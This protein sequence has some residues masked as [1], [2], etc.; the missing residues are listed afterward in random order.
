MK[1][2]IAHK[3]AELDAAEE[4]LGRRKGNFPDD[5]TAKLNRR[6][7]LQREL[8]DLISKRNLV[9]PQ[10][11]TFRS[12]SDK[13]LHLICRDGE[14]GALPDHIRH[15]GPWQAMTR[16]EVADLKQ[17]ERRSLIEGGGY[18][19]ERRTLSEF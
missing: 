13:N 19:V 5:I 16:G 9:V 18:V 10:Y 14:Y 6:G 3:Q 4:N 7:E 1:A 2:A 17:P 12:L 11:Q 8:A 15:Q